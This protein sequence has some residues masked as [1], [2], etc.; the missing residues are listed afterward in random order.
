MKDGKYEESRGFQVGD[1]I[2]VTDAGGLS[3]VKDGEVGMVTGFRD[4]GVIV[5]FDDAVRP[6]NGYD[7]GWWVFDE[8]IELIES[9]A[10]TASTA[11][12]VER[13]VGASL[14]H[15]TFQ[16]LGDDVTIHITT[17]DGDEIARDVITL[18]QFNE[19]ARIINEEAR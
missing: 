19:V 15:F 16:R 4:G 11:S 1:K 13:I 18:A 14:D 10:P 5:R 9:V 7:G 6:T 2:R 12:G 8:R 3:G 17:I